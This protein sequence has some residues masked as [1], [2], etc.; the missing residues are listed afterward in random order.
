MVIELANNNWDIGLGLRLKPDAIEN[1]QK[2]IDAIGQNKSVTLK[3]DNSE[4]L[5]QINAVKKQ[6][7]SL[8][9]VKITIGNVNT[10]SNNNNVQVPKIIDGAST[11]SIYTV[12]EAYKE[13]KNVIQQIGSKELNLQNLD[14]KTNPEQIK[15]LKNQLK[16]LYTEFDKIMDE[17]SGRF[18]LVQE[19]DIN[20][21]LGNYSRKSQQLSSKLTDTTN[22]Q[23]NINAYQ[24]LLDLQNQISSKKISVAKLNPE[25]NAFEIESIT[26]QIEK[27]K[28]EYN[29]LK[30]Q[31][32]EKLTIGQLQELDNVSKQTASDIETIKAKWL[33]VEA[34]METSQQNKEVISGYKQLLDLQNQISSKKISVAKL[35]PEKDANAIATIKAQIRELESAYSELSQQ[36]SGK[37]S[38]SQIQE[39]DN[40]SKQTA[41]DIEIIK[42]K[43]SDLNTAQSNKANAAELKSQFRSLLNIANEIGDIN[44]KISKLGFSG[45][46]TNQIKVL[47][48]Q[49]S[50]LINTYADLKVEFEN[51]GGIDVVGESTFKQLDN[52]ITNANNRLK[53]FQATYE[54][55]RAK[56]ANKIQTDFIGTGKFSADIAKVQADFQK[57]GI[58][59]ESVT[60]GITKLKSLLSTMSKSNDVEVVIKSYETYQQVLK[61]TQNDVK[62]LQ[63]NA[64]QASATLSLNA[65][66]D[67]MNRSIELWFK[68]N[69]AL[70]KKFGIEMRNIQT[71]IKLADATKLNALQDQLEAVKVKAQLA[72]GSAL[73]FGDRLKAQLSKLGIYFSGIMLITR[74]VQVIKNMVNS[75]I[76][77]DTS[78]IDLKKTTTATN[79]ELQAFYFNANDIGKELGTTTKAVVQA[80]ADWSRLGFSIKDAQEMAKTS[81][82]FASISPGVDINKATDGLVSAMKAYKIEAEDALDGVASKINIIGNTQAVSNEDIVEFLTRSSSAMAVANNTLDETIALGTAITEVTRDAA[83]AGQVMKTASMRIRGYDEETQELSSDVQVLVGDIANLTKTA[84]HPIGVSI[85]SDEAKTQYKSTVEIL[86]EIS[87][88]WDELTD[89][90]QAQVLE[91]LGGKRGGQALAAAIEN[92]S[93]VEKSLNTMQHSA[94]NAMQEMSII[95][96]SLEFKLNKLKETG[97][98]VSQNV[99]SQKEISGIITTLTKLLEVIDN[100]TK[101]VGGLG[102]AFTGLMAYKGLRG[103]GIFD[104]FNQGG[105]SLWGGL[106]GLFQRGLSEQAVTAGITQSDIQILTQ[107]SNA[108]KMG[109]TD[110]TA[111]EAS[112]K[113]ASPAAKQMATSIQAGTVQLNDLTTASKAAQ[114]G[115]NLLYTAMNI[116]IS[117]FISFAINKISKLA[118]AYKDL[119]QKA[120]EASQKL[121][122]RKEENSQIDELIEKYKKL[123]EAETADNKQETRKQA[124]GLQKEISNIIAKQPDLYNKQLKNIDLVNGSLQEQL[125]LLNKI[126]KANSKSV[127]TSAEQ[128]YRLA[129]DATEKYK[130]DNPDSETINRSNNSIILVANKGNASN[131]LK[132]YSIVSELLK[133][134]FMGKSDIDEGNGNRNNEYNIRFAEDTTW[135]QRLKFLDEAIEKLEQSTEFDTSQK[136]IYDQLLAAREDINKTVGK[137]IQAAVDY[138]QIVTE[139]TVQDNMANVKSYKEFEAARSKVINEVLANGTISKAITDEALSKEDIEQYVNE[140][141]S[142]LN[143]LSDY[144]DEW[145]RRNKNSFESMSDAEKAWATQTRAD[146]DSIAN[147]Y[148]DTYSE[149]EAVESQTPRTPLF[150]VNQH[151][152]TFK[153]VDKAM[154]SFESAIKNIDNNEMP[155]AEFFSQFPELA[156]YADDLTV[157]K[158][159]IYELMSSYPDDVIQELKELKESIDL[160]KESLEE[161]L[162]LLSVG[163]KVDLTNRPVIDTEELKK[164]GWSDVEGDVATVY[165][166]GFSNGESGKKAIAI[167]FTPIVVD[168][169]G[170]FI[171]V[172]S[173]DELE[174]YAQGVIAGTRTDDLHLQIG[175]K[176]TG[177]KAV[178]ESEAEAE[179]IH[180]LQEWYYTY[181]DEQ[182]QQESTKQKKQID[183]LITMLDRLGKK[184]KEVNGELTNI[185]VDDYIK[186]EEDHVQ[187]IIDKLESEKD[188]QNDILDSLKEQ[189]EQLEQIISDYEKTVSVVE[190]Y[191][192][193]I[194]IK[195]LE[196]QKSDVEEYYNTQIDKLKEENDERNRNIELQEKQD[197]LANARKTKAKVYTEAQGWIVKS[198]VNAIK[199]AE[200]ELKDLQNDITIDNLEKQ[201][202]SEINDIEKQIKAWED[203]K[204]AWKEQVE[205]ITEADEELIA[206]KILGADWH[207]KIADQDI[208]VMSNFGAEYV[209]YNNQLKNQVNVEISNVEKAIKEREKEIKGWKDY[210]SQ[211][212]NL[213]KEITNSNN[214]YLEN[215]NE[216]VFNENSTWEERIAHLKR[217]AEIVKQLN[218]DIN[219]SESNSEEDNTERY[220]VVYKGGIKRIRTNQEDAEN[221]K[222]QL[223]EQM[224]KKQIVPGMPTSAIEAI[225]KQLEKSFTIEKYATGGINTTTG[226]AWLDG[227]KNNSE[228][229]FNSAQA[230]KLYD[231][232]NS[233]NFAN[234]IKDNI[235]KGLD[236]PL[237]Q[238]TPNIVNN[239]SQSINITFPNATINAKDYD[240]FKSFM[241]T[242]T[243]D[244]MLKMQVGL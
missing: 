202:D 131:D 91:A 208:D 166:S 195:P 168:E 73:T 67:K 8:S 144:Y 176:F 97:V 114:I 228:V 199:N 111:L 57:L 50:N 200:K 23:E 219:S 196:Q 19:N 146:T 20:R 15:A 203:Y 1:I 95:E 189:K 150:D 59:N 113:G 157:L 6:I 18:T 52:I 30:Q 96:E 80:A 85:F 161:E 60:N 232:V 102:T 218:K 116:G 48:T 222:K 65:K 191:I 7:E 139:Y 175:A 98:G 135:V 140:Y 104:Y 179:K 236:K 44:S 103:V 110:T 134:R 3:I 177:K 70:A 101:K 231:L 87:K 133:Q 224:V 71:Q 77:L 148:K 55:T 186:K 143:G 31:L 100:L 118:N 46:N 180:K 137:Q 183:G 93:A 181:N 239:T 105:K 206:S 165:T 129:S 72:G 194:Q 94:G 187:G 115:M 74:S 201:R 151:T 64:A 142:S 79:E 174:E 54:D 192:D 182:R 47:Q 216:F 84:Q 124:L 204:D 160:S 163:G 112:L 230:Q 86:R 26:I 43:L 63:I 123:K 217:S 156:Q 99:F 41:S 233:G 242:Y 221:E 56:F 243:N 171:G 235:L 122:A 127:A 82:I 39:L 16:D 212:S 136:G 11:K 117:L 40:V 147:I 2:K 205:Q 13:L 155:D 241:D 42:A 90:Q 209:S 178:E 193:K 12:T 211:I 184:A 107:Y 240:T 153:D 68:N 22:V 145:V 238:L 51:N 167:N 128:A 172:L 69:S 34:K 4:A 185:S 215:F 66:K 61:S 25:K 220:A 130:Y 14:L 29:N 49:L 234:S 38:S 244:L 9:Q 227:T 108:L 197:A 214:E 35:D 120:D 81:S 33:D 37:L 89:K 170:E 58:E 141:I 188:V 162:K 106:T 78:L 164:A 32:S 27:L 152:E 53:V 24:K 10:A 17:Y 36:M 126:D 207:E 83:N 45:N 223:I 121:N 229:I 154:S 21:L 138:S 198:D 225:R 173:P 62:Q 210:K 226:L 132:G 213:N 125:E 76:D 237:T 119:A 88:V 75:V 28:T 5:K 109:I 159:K 149:I 158:Q 169:K 92:F 190:K